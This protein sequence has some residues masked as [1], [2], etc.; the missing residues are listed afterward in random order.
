MS[1]L[2][3]AMDAGQTSALSGCLV[4]AD[5]LNRRFTRE[6]NVV[7]DV[8]CGIHEL[9]DGRWKL[10]GPNTP[11]SEI[12]M[13]GDDGIRD[14]GNWREA[15]LPRVS[16]IASPSVWVGPRLI[17][18]PLAKFGRNWTASLADSRAEI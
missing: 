1:G 17:A 3:A 14:C 18:A 7:S 11:G 8:S 16:L 10:N 4:S 6:A 15:G 9:W 12:R 13:L 5:G 2:I